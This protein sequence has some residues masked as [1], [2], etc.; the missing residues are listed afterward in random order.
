MDIKKFVLLIIIAFQQNVVFDSVS[1]ENVTIDYSFDIAN[2]LQGHQA[3]CA[4][5]T[6]C[7]FLRLT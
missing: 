2:S 3:K 6:K 5:T 4:I 7:R 1:C